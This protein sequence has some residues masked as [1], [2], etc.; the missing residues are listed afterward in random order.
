M[1]FTFSEIWG[2]FSCEARNGWKERCAKQCWAIMLSDEEAAQLPQDLGP[3]AASFILKNRLG[4]AVCQ[5]HGG[6]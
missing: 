1:I 3:D 5:E 6:C 2:P 4:I